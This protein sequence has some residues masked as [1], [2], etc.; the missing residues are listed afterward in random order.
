MC[1]PQ[2]A[3]CYCK[4]P[5][6]KNENGDCILREQCEGKI[7]RYFMNFTDERNFGIFFADTLQICTHAHETYH[8][9]SNG[10]QTTCS[11]YLNPP[12]CTMQCSTELA[13]CYCDYPY[14]RS[15]NGDCVLEEECKTPSNFVQ[16]TITLVITLASLCFF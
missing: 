4:S 2:L 15:E 6:V 7:L 9:C 1:Q 5:F 16:S 8:G 10:C 13:G 3:G 14:V 12:M 11:N